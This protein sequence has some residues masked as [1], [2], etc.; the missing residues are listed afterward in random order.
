[1]S[2]PIDREALQAKWKANALELNRLYMLPG[3]VRKMDSDRIDALEA[4]Q[5]ALEFKLTRASLSIWSLNNR[6][7]ANLPIWWSELP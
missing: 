4:E 5:D 6:P 3:P 1:M 2:D 7:R